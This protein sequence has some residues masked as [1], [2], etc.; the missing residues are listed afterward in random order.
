MSQSFNISVNLHGLDEDL[1]KVMDEYPDETARFLRG[2]AN[3]WKKDCNAKGYGN[4]KYQKG[5]KPIASNWETVKE[6]NILHQMT[7]IEVRNKSSLFHLLENG[8]KKVLFGRDTGGFVEGKH[9]AEK[10]REEWDGKLTE[11]TRAY[12][13]KMLEGAGL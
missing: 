1:Q 8:H 5:K 4:Y 3:K 10:T 7:R 12:V 9:W 11:D 13:N 6:E 2:E